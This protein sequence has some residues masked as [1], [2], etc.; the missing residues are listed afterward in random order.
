LGS[1]IVLGMTFGSVTGGKL[2]TIGRRKAIMI[3]TFIGML[4]CCLTFNLNFLMLILGRFIFGFSCGMYSSIIPRYME[5]TVPAEYYDTVGA[6]FCFYQMLGVILSYVMGGFLPK[7]DDTA[8][9]FATD[10]WRIIYVYFPVS[11]HFITVF[12]LVFILR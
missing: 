11:M 2:M 9:L 8:G 1:A 5:E 3:S 6:S 4:G 10:K 7:D 12:A